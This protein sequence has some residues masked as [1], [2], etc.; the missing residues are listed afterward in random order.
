MIEQEEWRPW[1]NGDYEVSNIG[2]V[3]R[4]KPGRRTQVGRELKRLKA[5]AGYWYVGPTIGGKNVQTAVHAMVA[6]VFLGPRPDGAVVNH[7]DGDKLNARASNLEYITQRENMQH[8]ARAG[9]MVR[10]EQ[11]YN[12]KLT[13]EQV[14]ELRAH[15][16][17]GASFSELA[18]RFN[19][20]IANV[21]SIVHGKSRR[22]A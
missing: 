12:A 13:D 19:T 14:R 10:G 8:A 15:R 22:S 11:H 17:R 18:R 16:A 3:R 2:R 6:E 21:F 7:I 20:C 1:R 4:A 9:L 5:G